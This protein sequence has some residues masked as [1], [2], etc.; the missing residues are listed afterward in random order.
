MTVIAKSNSRTKGLL[1]SIAEVSAI[2]S[3]LVVLSGCVSLDLFGGDK[4]DRSLSTASVPNQLSNGPQTDDATIRNAVTSAD[5]TKL[6]EQPLPWANA[7]TGSAGVVTTIR[8]DKSSGFVCRDFKTT[9]HSFEGVA[10]Y[11][12]QA[13]MSETGEWLLTRFEQK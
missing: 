11:T 12:G 3:M 10:S 8:E 5:L 13:C 6:A 7:A 9:R 2:V 4:I 1:S